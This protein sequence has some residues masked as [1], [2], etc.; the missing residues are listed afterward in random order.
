MAQNRPILHLNLDPPDSSTHAV[1]ADILGEALVLV[2]R[3]LRYANTA[4]NRLIGPTERKVLAAAQNYKFEAF[5][6]A[7]SSFEVRLQAKVEGD[8]MFGHTPHVRALRKF[9]ELCAVVDNTEAA[10]AVAKENRGHFVTAIQALMEFVSSTNTPISYAWTTPRTEPVSHT[11]GPSAAK[12][13]YEQ[14]VA[15]EELTREEVDLVGKI[16][17]IDDQRGSWRLEAGDGQDYSGTVSAAGGPALLTGLV[18]GG[19]YSLKCIEFLKET[20]GSGRESRSWEL[21]A[22]PQEILPLP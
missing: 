17:L 15:K 12:A 1:D 7:A 21:I 16:H 22:P 19:T 3:A 4:A 20:R 10:V 13:L 11:I 14:L 18:S 8:P 2:Q 6:T 5:A 9:D